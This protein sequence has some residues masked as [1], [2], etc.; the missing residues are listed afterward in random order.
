MD[1]RFCSCC[2]FCSGFSPLAPSFS[3][4]LS[5]S[6]LSTALVFEYFFCCCSDFSTAVSV[7]VIF[8]CYERALSWWLVVRNRNESNEWLQM[9]AMQQNTWVVQG[10]I[11]ILIILQGEF[12]L[13]VKEV[14]SCRCRRNLPHF[15]HGTD[16]GPETVADPGR[17]YVR[18]LA[19]V[20]NLEIEQFYVCRNTQRLSRNYLKG[21]A[22]LD[23]KPL[24]I[25]YHEGGQIGSGDN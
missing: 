10:W 5:D 16:Q 21:S 8:C 14:A 4:C 18:A 2:D 6:A 9:W 25:L 11:G 24:F 19:L 1:F 23:L 12:V 3:H 22:L 13:D 17:N 15:R 20:R 7:T